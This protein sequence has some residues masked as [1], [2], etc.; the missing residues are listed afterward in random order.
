MCRNACLL[1][2]CATLVILS[3]SSSFGVLV[4]GGDLTIIDDAGNPSDGLRYLDMSFSDGLDLSAALTNAQTT[5]ANARLAVP[6]E[7]DDL[8]A[9]AGITYDGALMAS[10]G[11]AVGGAATISSG[12]NYDGGALLSLLG[13]T[14][15]SEITNIWTDPDGN[16]DIG[17]TRDFI[18]FNT[19][20]AQILNATS[21]A[22][23]A[24]V[25]WL[26]VTAVPEPSSFLLLGM[27]TAGVLGTSRRR[28]QR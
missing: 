15:G 8:F 5:Y 14:V 26:L 10:D 20:I 25:G 11:F 27:A 9:A 12:S 13:P 18:N 21:T 6:S 24:A 28:V 7:F 2:L 16:D 3:S 4:D 1:L 22:P 17:T 23:D 19:S